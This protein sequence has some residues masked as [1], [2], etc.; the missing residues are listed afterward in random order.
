MINFLK[1]QHRAFCFLYVEQFD[2]GAFNR[3]KLLSVGIDM[4]LKNRVENFGS[5]DKST[6]TGMNKIKNCFITHD[7]DLIPVVAKNLYTCYD[8]IAIHMCDKIDKY[9][10]QSQHISGNKFSA[11]GILSI[12]ETMFKSIN[13]FPNRYFG[14]GLED[15][16]ITD[17]L[18]MKYKNWPDD[19]NKQYLEKH[20]WYAIAAFS[21]D[22][23]S[24]N[25]VKSSRF[26]YYRM[27]MFGH[28]KAIGKP[29][30]TIWSGHEYESFKH[31]LNVGLRPMFFGFDGYGNLS[32]RIIDSEHDRESFII[33]VE[34]RQFIPKKILFN[35]SNTSFP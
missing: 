25:Y 6:D 13:G 11:G 23:G 17:R 32:Y 19:W 14:W 4:I 3:A 5:T 24:R 2:Q 15:H 33:T 21:E 34:I 16:D 35:S 12:S 29:L 20:L 28:S 22:G 8:H 26:G 31:F 9:K 10:Y 27:S 7:I 18:L 1:Y 30:S